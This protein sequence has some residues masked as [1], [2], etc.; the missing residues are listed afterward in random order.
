MVNKKIKKILIFACPRTGTTIIQK[1][2][3]VDLFDIPNLIEP[4]NDPELGFNP[5]NPKIVNGKPANLYKWTEEQKIGVMKLLASNLYY[6][7]I[8]RLL[9]VGNFD[10]V[11]IIERKNLVDCCISLYLAEQTTKYHYREGDAINIDPFECSAA[12]IDQWIGMYK[13]YLSALEQVKNSST[14]YDILCYEDFMEDKIQYVAGVELQLSKI[15]FK[16][17]NTGKKLIASQLPYQELCINYA[18]VE[19]KMKECGLI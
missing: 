15:A 1:R 16:V 11:V 18:K 14:P 13:Q 7:D 2:L 17:F 9:S 6:I 8:N 5:A 10:R 4:F 19:E 3:S 12:F